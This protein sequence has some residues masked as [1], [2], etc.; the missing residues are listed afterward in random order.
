MVASN[1]IP[2]R[3]LPT[4]PETDF[5]SALVTLHNA[6]A[7]LSDGC[8]KAL[9]LLVASLA[10]D[11]RP[12]ESVTLPAFGPFV[13][14]TVESV[15]IVRIAVWFR[16]RAACWAVMRPDAVRTD[17]ETLVRSGGAV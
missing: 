3:I 13:A 14:T 10:E 1:P 6:P 8:V 17:I 7:V 12:G 16:G 15:D 2:A 11:V 4:S 5:L 9:A